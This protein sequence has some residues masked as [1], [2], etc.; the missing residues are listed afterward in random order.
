MVLIGM[1]VLGDLLYLGHWPKS[2]GDDGFSHIYLPSGHQ[3]WKGVSPWDA[4]L[5][6]DLMAPVERQGH[7][8]LTHSRGWTILAF[9]D[10]TASRKPGSVSAFIGKGTLTFDGVVAIARRHYPVICKRVGKVRLV[11]PVNVARVG[12][13]LGYL[14]PDVAASRP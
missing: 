14:P 4:P 1:T 10:T 11:D 8:K 6:R 2:L 13:S 5:G 7:A 9:W 3:F 12:C